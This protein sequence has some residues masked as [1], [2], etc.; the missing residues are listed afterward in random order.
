VRQAPR[1]RLPVWHYYF[2]AIAI[3]LVGG[4]MVWSWWPAGYPG[5]DELVKV[6]GDIA[7]TVVRDDLS[8]SSA[9]AFMPAMT[10]V[11][12]TL[13]GIEGEFRYPSSHPQYV[14]VRD[15]TAVAMDV[16]VEAAEIGTG[17]PMT[18]W[19]IEERSPYNMVMPRTVIGYGDIVGELIETDRSMVEAGSWLL[20]IAAALLAAGLLMGHRN[21]GLPPLGP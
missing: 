17:R 10:A 8:D 11:Y 9:G 14:S 3:G 5:E 15:Y 19:A 18:I 12:F 16:W 13:K 20:A 21:R 6:S 7:R 2:L 1:S 4:T